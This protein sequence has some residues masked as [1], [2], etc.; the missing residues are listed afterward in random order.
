M[1]S[2]RRERPSQIYGF[3]HR[4]SA[5]TGL[6]AVVLLV[7]SF[8]VVGTDVPT[9]DDLPQQ[10]ASFYADKATAIEWSALLG[11][12]GIGTFVWFAGLLRWE[13]GTAEQAARGFQQAAPIMFGSALAGAAISLVFQAA[14]ETAVVSQGIASPGA[15]RAFDLF[16]AYA[17]TAAAAVLSVFLFAAFFLI[18]TTKVLPQWLSVVAVVGAGLGIVQAVVL[19]APQG[20]DGVLGALGYAWFAVFLVWTLGASVV[21]IRRNP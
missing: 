11:I 2:P 19:L 8:L 16:G 4:V 17:L 15:V 13:F 14:H 5:T 1:A 18:R 3:S 7:A 6:A 9:Y 12:F 20:D 21:L 10:F